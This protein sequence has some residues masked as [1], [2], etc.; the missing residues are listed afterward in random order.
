M[1]GE[2]DKNIA[3]TTKK[4]YLADKSTPKY[5]IPVLSSNS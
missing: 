3:N 5:I 4:Q 2:E 1:D